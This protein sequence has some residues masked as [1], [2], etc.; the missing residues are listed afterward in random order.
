MLLTDKSPASFDTADAGDSAASGSLF[1]PSSGLVPRPAASQPTAA[2]ASDTA[3]SKML[4]VGPGISLSGEIT[5][6]DRLVVEGTVKVALNRT[7]AI[8]IAQSGVFTEGKADVEEA[9]VSGIY[10]GDLTVRGRLL[11]RATGKVKGNVRYRELEVEQG[12]KLTGSLAAL[13]G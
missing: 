13:E 2:A 8:E 12:G 7:K 10:E 6:C 1:K 3:H 5:A 4:I 9:V 11:I